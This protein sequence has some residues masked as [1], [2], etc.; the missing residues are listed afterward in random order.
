MSETPTGRPGAAAVLVAV[1][2]VLSGCS[3]I[4]IGIG[5]DDA[6]SRTPYDVPSRTPGPNAG[7]PGVNASG[8]GSPFALVQAHVGTLRLD[9]FRVTRERTVR[10]GDGVRVTSVDAR[11]GADRQRYR[12]A[13][14]AGEPGGVRQEVYASTRRTDGGEVVQ[15]AVLAARLNGD[16]LLST[17]RV[18][19]L[20]G[21]SVTPR[22]VLP[23]T[24][25]YR[26]RLYRYLSVV[27]AASVERIEAASDGDDARYRIAATEIGDRQQLAPL[28]DEITR[29]DLT[30]TVT[31]AGFIEQTTV[32]YTVQQGERT[33][34]IS[35]RIEYRSIG[36][37]S[38][39]EPGW[40]ETVGTPDANETTNRSSSD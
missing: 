29:V 16:E 17:Q 36:S 14:D 21:D 39:T 27:E 38:I 33:R 28:A 3:G 2:V 5:G 7:P 12:I 13:I 24:P 32:E 30:L 35:E 40:F 34:R 15:M 11:I 6:E 26:E 31:G 25:G 4:G 23:G 22:Q 10:D 19:P 20:V 1:L 8:V 9:S 37:V 18:E